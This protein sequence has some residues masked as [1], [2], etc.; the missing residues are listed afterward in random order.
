MTRYCLSG[1]RKSR[2]LEASPFSL[3]ISKSMFATRQEEEAMK[4]WL[5]ISRRGN[6]TPKVTCSDEFLCCSRAMDVNEVD[7]RARTGC[8]TAMFFEC[9]LFENLEWVIG[10]G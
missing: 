7:G 3:F 4:S 5:T 8:N 9:A 2:V 10:D 1:G 6:C